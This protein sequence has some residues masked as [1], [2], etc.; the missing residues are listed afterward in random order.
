MGVLRVGWG[1]L[2]LAA[3]GVAQVP[4]LG[5]EFD[6]YVERV[7]REFEVPGLALAIVRDGRV[8]LERGYGV[9]ELG[10]PDTVDADTLFAIASNTKAFTAAALAQLVDEGR[11]AWTDRVIDRLPWFQM[12]DPYVTREMTIRDL[13]THR[14]GLA[15]GAGDLLFWPSTDFTPREIVER[16]RFVPLATG[17]RAT[18]A[19]DNILYAV[20]GV[21]IE[22]MAGRTWADV[23]RERIFLPAGMERTRA[24]SAGLVAADN[25]AT[26]HAKYDF[27]ELRA[28][29]SLAWDN[30]PAA[31]AICSS[32][33]DMAKWL[34]VL[35]DGGRLSA[36]PDGRER[37]LFSAAR[38][39][40]MW[41]VV[42]PMNISEP[43]VAALQVTRPNFLGYGLGWVLSDYRG[44]RLV[45]H[46]GG[47][48][49]QVSKVVLVPERKLGV[50][51]LTNQES[52]AAF[53]AL[54]WRI[55]DHYLGAPETDWVA[56]YADAERS[57]QTDAGKS[58]DRHVAARDAGSRPS[59]PL[60]GYA[61]TYRD[62]WRGDVNI[63][64]AAG[65]LTLA[66]SRTDRLGGELEH[67]QHDTF[68][69]RW[70]D[71]SH[72]A[73]AFVTFALTPDGGI[74]QVKMQAIS[75]LTDFSFDFHHLV[76]K[77]VR[78]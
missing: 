43:I 12:S 4:P 5:G 62:P 46:T 2:L 69:V 66:F 23:M 67:W 58:W 51:I 71:R 48:P 77:P 50:V 65:R 18:Y 27:K 14:S 15:L 25:I 59:L 53:Q 39:R 29:P 6:A 41:S 75:P 38:Q 45:G 13:L 44:H 73:D 19:Y 72:N 20:A 3:T 52:G 24:S 9:R 31:G 74:D 33:R 26:G 55:L 34:R 70:Q 60:A 35:L 42:T 47:W 10:L 37:R 16:L 21:T 61:G 22:Q 63:R 36:G 30:N 17:F 49:G 54:G 11:L 1:L 78:P 8:E 7:R 68:I 56:A 28:V 64:E 40:E 76:L 57:G 32:A